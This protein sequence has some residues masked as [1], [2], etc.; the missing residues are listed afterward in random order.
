[1]KFNRITLSFIRGG[2]LKKFFLI[3]KLTWAFILILNLQ[4]SASVWSQTTAMSLKLKNS[5]L[6]ELFSKI[7]KSSEYRFFYNNDDVDINQR[8][9]VDAEDKTIGTILEKALKGLPYSFR[10]SE[11][12]LIVIERTGEVTNP[13]GV[14]V[15]QGK[16]VT[17]KVTDSSG[18]SLP[19]VS[20]VVKGTTTG[21]ITD[22][23]GTYSL[24]NISENTILRFSFVGMKMQEIKVGNQKSINIVL[25]Q[26]TIGLEEVVAVGYGTQKKVTLTGAVSA[27]N[28]TELV[29]TKNENVLN[30][31]TGK[32]PGVRVVQ[33][34]SEP[35][36]FN[37]TF[38][39]RGLGSPL[40]IIDGVPRDNISRLDPNEIESMS[41]LK[42]ASAAIYGV[43]AANGVVL[44][45][46]KKGKSGKPELTYS[47][48]LGMQQ[49]IGLPESGDAI[50]EMTMMNEKT[51]T[52]LT[53]P[54][55]QYSDADFELYRS[56]K[57]Q[58]SN[59]KDAAMRNTAPMY[60]HNLSASGSSNSLNYY[61]NFGYLN[62]DGYWKSNDLNYKRYNVRANVD[63]QISKRLK[64][65]MKLS[66]I[67][68]NK[69]QPYAST[70]SV[71]KSLWRQSALSPVYA[72]NNP[73]YPGEAYDAANTAVITN[74]DLSGYRKYENKWFQGSM[75]LIYDVPYITGLVARGMYSYDYNTSV[76]KAYM[77][78]YSLYSYDAIKDTYTPHTAQS[79]STIN[80]E[81]Y[82]KTS[83]LMQLSLNYKRSFNEK[84]N[85]TGLL[86]Y[87]EGTSSGDN[88][89]AMRELSL[90]IDQLFAG[91]QLNQIGN[92]NLNGLYKFANK[93]LVGKFNYDYA[94]R[95]IAEFSFRYDGS[96][97]FKSGAQWG[98]FPA[99]S[100]GWRISEESFVK[101]TSSLSFIN[102]LKLRASY[103]KMGD[104]GAAAY[105][106]LTGY[107]YPNSGYIFNDNFINGLGFRGMP[108]YNLTWYTAKT[109]NIGLDATLWKGLLG[110]QIDV[111]QRDR[112]GLLG[113]RL[114]TLPGTVGAGMP[115]ENLNS[116]RSR[117]YELMLTHR[118]KI[119]EVNYN[120]SAI[121]SYTGT[122]TRYFERAALGNSYANW[123]NNNINR[124][125]NIW[126]GVDSK[127]FYNSY[128]EISTDQVNQGG[129]NLSSLPG[130]Y[131]YDDWNGDGVIDGNDQHP[132]GLNNV[133]LINYSFTAAADYKG[134]DIN[135]LF[136]G[137]AMSYVEYPEQLS[138]PF[139]WQNGNILT[140]FSDR[141]HPVDPKAD[142]YDP[143]SVWV[144]GDRPAM[145]RPI[146]QGTAAVQNASY[147]RL[148]SAEIGY[149]LPKPLLSKLGVGATRI[150]INGYNLFT[151]TS[152]K[153]IDPEHPS[154]SY[155]YLYPISRSF[156]VG[157]SVTF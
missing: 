117:G 85:V 69:D 149:T 143:S 70:E 77:K 127:G 64:T 48:N 139:V 58:S 38:D 104:D 150:Y 7:E 105:Q 74:S 113:N 125:N 84:H 68:D 23:D 36:E 90:P 15:Q 111:F 133:P 147:L 121:F 103:G 30:M 62:Q 59:W 82:E 9:S 101:N 66:G 89:M 83:T 56:G 154:D 109:A 32:V 124:N 129:G 63:A 12:K 115:Q 25:D 153:Y 14:N 100:V 42:D 126:W 97:K 79:P 96:S 22:A 137:S 94:S 116:D 80:R 3:M 10:E 46:T 50:N 128:N 120:L 102:N 87:E 76:N 114:M 17:G 78:E 135:L 34:S 92:M 112:S 122:Q 44:I 123:R 91:N 61:F 93:A 99:A 107:D 145:G 31:I 54:Y 108:N 152:I 33:K 47:Y 20:V 13:S 134:F 86:L 73:Q 142:R 140:M 43:R 141:W 67:M 57:K 35:G 144:A 52:N 28:A 37:N 138:Q 157:I 21:I 18:V 131:K 72:N 5:T 110:F 27:V 53:S 24:N 16:K 19:G 106:F 49:P 146:G 1:M 60:Q 39:I 151:V 4:M 75:A 45:T 29:T 26:E 65:E 55:L 8:I 119:G 2:G 148:K 118:S 71:F 11:N 6:Q 40:I 41:V 136:Q 130:D 132:I 88:F 155:G 98:F 81:F 95:Y 51:M 156:N